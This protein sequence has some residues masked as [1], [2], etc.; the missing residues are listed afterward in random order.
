MRPRHHSQAARGGGESLGIGSNLHRPRLFVPHAPAVPKRVAGM[1]VALG[2]TKEEFVAQQAL[3]YAVNAV[4][5]NQRRHEW[6]ALEERLQRHPAVGER[7]A[8]PLAEYLVR[9]PLDGRYL[10]DSEHLTQYQE[11]KRLEV[12]NLL[13][14]QHGVPP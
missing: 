4:V 13:R 7:V 6:P 11:A 1:K 2:Q 3:T 8:Q 12:C 10:V 5:R 9:L 14:R